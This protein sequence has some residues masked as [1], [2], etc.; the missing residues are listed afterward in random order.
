M[1]SSNNKDFL[2]TTISGKS[3]PRKLC[4][5][6]DGKYYETNVDCFLMDDERWHRINNG[7]IAFDNEGERWVLL[8]RV[9]LYEGIIG[10]DENKSAK[11]GSFSLNPAKNV[12]VNGVAKLLLKIALSYL[13][14]K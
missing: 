1:T 14:L 9:S 6:I 12:I 4:R 7:K 13:A 8:D 2:V 5:F 10:L 11:Y 3:I